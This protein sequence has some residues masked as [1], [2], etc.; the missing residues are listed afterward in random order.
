MK[1]KKIILGDK[2]EGV[3]KVENGVV[4]IDIGVDEDNMYEVFDIIL[5]M[6]EEIEEDEEED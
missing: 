3:V 6:I 4:K 5:K 2:V 1:G